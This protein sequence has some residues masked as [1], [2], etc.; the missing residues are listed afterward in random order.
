MSYWPQ[1]LAADRHVYALWPLSA[2]CHH[3]SYKHDAKELP[4]GLPC[5]SPCLAKA[6]LEG[7]T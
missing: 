1:T 4:F 2:G 6:S 7:R 3:T 5:Q